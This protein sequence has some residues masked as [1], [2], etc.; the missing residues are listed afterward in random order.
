L[1]RQL[2]KC[3]LFTSANT[4]QEKEKGQKLYCPAGVSKS[5]AHTVLVVKR[6]N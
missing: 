1:E 6:Q 4:A 5:A 3:F 2:A